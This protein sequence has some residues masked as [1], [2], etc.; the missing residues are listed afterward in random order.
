MDHQQGL[1][2]RQTA[3]EAIAH[4]HEIIALAELLQAET[5]SLIQ[6]VKIE[7]EHMLALREQRRSQAGGVTAD[8]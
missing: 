4:A 2:L 7:L 8:V 5:Q 3:R 1:E 6:E